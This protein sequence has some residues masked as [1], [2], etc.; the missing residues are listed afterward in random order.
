MIFVRPTLTKGLAL[1]MLS[2]V[3]APA[4]AQNALDR[5]DPTQVER[6]EDV[7]P[8]GED[9]VRV[10][11]YRIE[12]DA[13]VFDDLRYDVGAIVLDGLAALSP[14]D[15]TDI[16]QNYSARTLSAGELNA[17]GQR[18]AERARERGYIFASASPP[19][20]QSL[21]GGASI[22]MPTG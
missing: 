18:L 16:V 3:T 7:V 12:I 5:T 8:T 6:R 2:G 13:T 9:E 22:S 19:P 20:P 14:G 11:T 15:V 1:A 17:F 4:L 21:S 10:E